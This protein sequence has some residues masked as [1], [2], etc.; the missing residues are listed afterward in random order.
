VIVLPPPEFCIGFTGTRAGMTPAQSAVV[1]T[2]LHGL[3]RDS[4]YTSLLF[5]VH[6]DCVGAD[7]DFDELCLRAGF[8]ER[9]GI[10]PSDIPGLRASCDG[11]IPPAVVLHEPAPPL[12]RNPWIPLACARMIATPKRMEEEKRSG[13]SH[14]IRASRRLERE[15]MTVWP[16]GTTRYQ[17]R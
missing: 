17:W 1:E 16:D 15:I 11:K 5:A 2:I 4:D 8:G 10:Y 13:T 6:G 9:R 7:N 3:R 12:V 14:C